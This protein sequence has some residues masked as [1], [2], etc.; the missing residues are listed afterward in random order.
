MKNL[1]FS[2]LVA[3]GVLLAGPGCGS[4]ETT[5]G[6]NPN[7]V[8][9]GTVNAGVALPAGSEVVVRL[10]S[11]SG[12]NDAVRPTNSDVP[13]MTRPTGQAAERVLGE[14]IQT[15]AAGTM[16]PV[17]FRIEYTADDAVL[18]RG[19]NLDVRVSVGGKL[20][21][22]T[23]SAHVVTLASSPFRQDVAVQSVAR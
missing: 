2:F 21:Y 22:R 7:R 13:V 5:V 14:H 10:I 20:S 4:I 12:G 11:V 17:P 3:L 16:D 23:V 6:G 8:L 18:R 15:L 1:R 9:T 19:L